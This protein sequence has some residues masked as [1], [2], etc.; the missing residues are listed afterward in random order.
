M[1]HFK[2]GG[3]CRL[4][5]LD[6]SAKRAREAKAGANNPVRARKCLSEAAK[7]R[8]GR[9]K[10]I[11]IE[12]ERA[13]SSAKRQDERAKHYDFFKSECG[14]GQS[15]RESALRKRSKSAEARRS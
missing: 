11:K 14:R 7:S 12:P 2:L 8:L 13:C 10:W 1:E 15:D 4:A 3:N 6:V 5:M 9:S